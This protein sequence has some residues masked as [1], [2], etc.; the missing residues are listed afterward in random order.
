MTRDDYVQVLRGTIGLATPDPRY[1]KI[2]TPGDT[3][4]RAAAIARGSSE[5]I[6]VALGGQELAWDLP[7][8][9]AYVPASAPRILEDRTGGTPMHPQGAMRLATL[10]APPRPGDAVWYGE[11]A[12]LKAEH[13]EHV[14]AAEV[15]EDDTLTVTCVAGGERTTAN[16]PPVGRECVGLVK[17]TL[18]WTGKAWT[19][20]ANGRPVIGVVDFDLMC[21][22]YQ[23]LAKDD[24]S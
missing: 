21:E 10:E 8:R 13:V 24:N 12:T 3:A 17:R 4:E 18:D 6:L 15:T 7:A 23:P 20:R 14:I 5:C 9:P 19:D 16:A 22:R 1:L 11:S 2:A